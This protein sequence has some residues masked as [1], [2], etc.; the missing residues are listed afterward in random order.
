V[1]FASVSQGHSGIPKECEYFFLWLEN[2]RPTE[3]SLG[4][5][6]DRSGQCGAVITH[7]VVVVV[8]VMVV[9]VVPGI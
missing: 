1:L 5:S 8:G 3:G 4:P 2:T 6:G 7:V 9:G